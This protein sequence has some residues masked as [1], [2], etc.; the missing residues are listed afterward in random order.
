M[1]SDWYCSVHHIVGREPT[2]ELEG[3][4]VDAASS[5][6]P[7]E[8]HIGFSQSRHYFRNK[9][10]IKPKEAELYMEVILIP[11]RIALY[12]I[13]CAECAF[14]MTSPVP[15][16]N[17]AHIPPLSP[18]LPRPQLVSKLLSVQQEAQEARLLRLLGQ[19]VCP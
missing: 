17:D 10:S 15:C 16:C 3:G 7:Q 12:V 8:I 19:E 4:K 1:H 11:E 14:V 2:V 5:M 6:I 18:P 13:D 9:N